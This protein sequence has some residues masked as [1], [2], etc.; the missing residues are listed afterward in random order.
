[1]SATVAEFVSDTD[2]RRWI[3]PRIAHLLGLADAPVGDRQELF[4]AWRTF[5]ERVAEAGPTVM[6]FEDLQWADPGLIDFIES[7]LEW[8][9]A[10]PIFVVTLARPELVDRR[11]TWGAGQR[12]FSSLHLEPLHEE[13]LRQLLA[14]FVEGLPTTVSAKILE[15]SEG[16]PL[17][18]VEMVRSLV[19][20]GALTIG[21]GTYVVSGDLSGFE[22]PETL[23]ALIGSRLDSLPPEQ[24]SLLQDAAILGTSFSLASLALLQE[25]EPAKLETDLRDLV[26]KEFLTFDTNPLSPERG[27]YSFVQ[28]L[29]QEVARSRMSRRDRS[30]KHLAI[31][32]YYESLEDSELAA[33]VASHYVEASLTAG[34]DARE[35]IASRATEWLSR[36]GERALSLGSPE[37]A[38]SLFE[39]ALELTAG[40]GD[41]AEML[42]RTAEAAYRSVHYDR[43]LSL[44]EEAFQIHRSAGDER[45]AGRANVRVVA[46]LIGQARFTE[47]FDRA[48]LALQ[49]SQSLDITTQANLAFAVAQAL[50]LTGR[51]EEA[52]PRAETAL[53]LAEESGDL[54]LLAQA[55]GARAQSLFQVGRHREAVVLARGMARLA[56]EAGS[57]EE[58]SRALMGLSVFLLDDDPAGSF[59]ISLSGAELSRRSGD[60]QR[61]QVNLLNAAESAVYIGKWTDARRILLS[62]A[63][64]EL[65][66]QQQR[67]LR[68]VEGLLVA[69]T[70]HPADGL[71]Q[72]EE[73]E[74]RTA[75]QAVA[76]M[77]TFLNAR[78]T[79]KLAAGDLEGARRDA[80]AAVEADPN[81][82]NT[83]IALSTLARACLWLH[84]LA[85]VEDAFSDMQSF[86]GRWMAAVRRTA[87]A[88][89]A[90]IQ[91]DLNRSRQLYESA[92]D[93]W[94]PLDCLFDLALAKLD[95][96]LLLE[97]SSEGAMGN[98]ARRALTEL[99]ALPF[100]SKLD[101]DH[102]KEAGEA[103]H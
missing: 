47:A 28:A 89:L 99:G 6:I 70:G 1:M 41:R 11:P 38:E 45:A 16:V 2:E 40:N 37:Q 35:E 101:A 76:N 69:V 71:A 3:E 4:S 43:A 62:L 48:E 67:W 94:V 56:E 30:A 32:R 85:G 100:L 90:A 77:T 102:T 72:I 57:L 19:D 9:R 10:H 60:R 46:T 25:V 21:D 59:S 84:D 33:V 36:A 54:R 97:S 88:G 22:I 27:Q 15:R 14:G 8:S 95:A 82:I 98:D 5:F 50:T 12:S 13:A 66:S 79:A 39:Q 93:G 75:E 23:Q 92:F 63:D 34:E 42:E 44:A 18:A 83:P 87:E 64:R 61:E 58:Q 86:R 49:Q 73:G 29:L 68:M 65:T 31:A 80:A 96:A 103:P 55:I 26:R 78:A 24:R 7:I 81:G 91:G 74:S 51:S 20:R 53:T 52:L 17:Y